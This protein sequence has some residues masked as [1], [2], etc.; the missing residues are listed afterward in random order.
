M[1]RRLELVLAVSALLIAA[2]LI[3]AQPPDRPQPRAT[4]GI[5]VGR[6]EEGQNEA[7][8]PVEAVEPDGPGAK[9]GLREGDVITKIGDRDVRGPEE[10]VK[11]LNNH[12]PGDHV[13]LHVRRDGKD[14]TLTVQL[15]ERPG[16][17]ARAPGGGQRPAFLGVQLGESEE[18]GQ[19]GV[20]VRGVLPE[21]PA[22]KAGLRDGDVIT[23][24][25]GKAV[26]GPEELRDTVR[27]AG[28]GKEL[29][30]KVMRGKDT[31]ELTARLEEAPAGEISPSG[32]PA[33][34][35]VPPRRQGDAGRVDQLERR[36]RELERRVR[37]LEKKEGAGQSGERK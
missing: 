3:E 32:G 23:E 6:A 37:E 29:H 21:S 36:I 34:E 15:G 14:Q 13:T 30:L 10:L 1:V 33:A 16:R 26:R 35:G 18:E 28:A 24:A 25:N 17:A 20:T 9:A 22:D 7:G 27:Q 12:K 2:S 5:A 8:V 4:L 19:K 11:T 31:K